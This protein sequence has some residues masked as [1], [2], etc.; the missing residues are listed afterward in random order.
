VRRLA[1]SI[2][3][4][5][6]YS[7][8]EAEDGAA[9]LSLIDRRQHPDI[10]L[11]LTDIVM[12]GMSGRDLADHVKRLSP[13]TAILFMSGYPGDI[14]GSSDALKHPLLPKPFTPTQLAHAA[15]AAIESAG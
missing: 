14:V 9:A 5:C 6:G 11:V 2:L 4:R 1:S 8:V 15:K 13:G 7:V 10:R 12:P 3:K